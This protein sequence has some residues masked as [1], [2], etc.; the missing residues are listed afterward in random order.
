MPRF[1]AGVF[2]VAQGREPSL[3]PTACTGMLR[4]LRG[5]VLSC[6]SH[7]AAIRVLSL[8]DSGFSLILFPLP[9]TSCPAVIPVRTKSISNVTSSK[10]H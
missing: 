2:A 10:R 1:P 6:I 9:T 5:L 3:A 7:H 4:I 8:P